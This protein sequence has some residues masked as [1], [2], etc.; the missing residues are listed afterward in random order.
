MKTLSIVTAALI[1]VAGVA[2]AQSV[3]VLS[4]VAATTLS[5]LAPTV[6]AG[7]LSAIQIAEL[8]RAAVSSEG[9]QA[10][11]LYSILRN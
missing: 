11:D 10:S 2:S 1:A 6:D 8:N 4:S 7:S 9:L 5:T 3:P